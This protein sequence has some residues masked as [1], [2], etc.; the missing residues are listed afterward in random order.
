MSHA[1]LGGERSAVVWAGYSH[2]QLSTLQ[3]CPP[4]ANGQRCPVPSQWPRVI[5][6][7]RICWIDGKTG[8]PS[9]GPIKHNFFCLL[10]G[11]RYQRARFRERFSQFGA[12]VMPM[13]QP[14]RR[15]DL[16][17][18]ILVLLSSRDPMSKR[19]IARAIQAQESAVRRAVDELARA[20]QLQRGHAW[21]WMPV[22]GD[23]SPGCPPDSESRL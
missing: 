22:R 18:E 7:P 10:G 4:L 3:R 21:S 15:R 1:L 6:K 19:A 11:D 23:L 20:G 13:R 16:K 9:K 5:V 2:E 12:C 17:R 8:E 14:E